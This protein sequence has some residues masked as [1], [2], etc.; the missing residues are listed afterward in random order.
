MKKRLSILSFLLAGILLMATL[1]FSGMVLAQNETEQFLN[2]QDFDTIETESDVIYNPWGDGGKMTFGLSGE[3]KSSGDY[4]LKIQPTWPKPVENNNNPGMAAFHLTNAKWTGY[5]YLE[6]WFKNA[7]TADATIAIEISESQ[8]NKCVLT[9]GNVLREKTDGSFESIANTNKLTIPSGYAGRIRIPLASFKKQWEGVTPL[10]LE[11]DIWEIAFALDVKDGVTLYV[12]SIK[13]R[14]TAED[15]AVDPKPVESE[16]SS[17]PTSSQESSVLPET[18]SVNSGEESNRLVVQNFENIEKESDVVYNPWG[19][20]GAMTFGLNGEQTNDGEKALK[21]QPTWPKP[22]ATN[23]NPGL[24]S[25]HLTNADWTGYSYVEFWFKNTGTVAATFKME[26][27]ESQGNKCEMYPGTI[28][29]E[30]RNGDFKA[31]KSTEYLTID[32][33]FEGKVRIPLKSFKKQYEGVTELKANNVWEVLLAFDVE[34]NKDAVL[35]VDSVSVLKENVLSSDHPNTGV[36]GAP[37]VGA[38]VFGLS[39]LIACTAAFFS[40][41]KHCN[42]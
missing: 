37:I 9:E 36:S 15:P 13:G 16:T 4:S 32:S 3:Q 38:A 26:I 25:F 23:F 8:G 6:F 28:Y 24:V 5:S 42:A 30:Q 31:V 18:S 34:A 2:I 17:A 35:Y 11:K 40:G 33:G 41:K 7:G 10:D 14:K 27:N 39:A 19:D 12:D 21:I 29:V 20:G 22:D 1:A